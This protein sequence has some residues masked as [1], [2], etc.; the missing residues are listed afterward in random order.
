MEL[1]Q[2]S[3]VPPPSDGKTSLLWR[4]ISLDYDTRDNEKYNRPCIS[5]ITPSYNQGQFIEETIRSVLS[6][7]Y[8]NLEYV[9]IDGASTDNTVSI[10]QKYSG[11]LIWISEPDNGQT[12]AINKGLRMSTGEIVAY[13]N[14]DDVYNEGTFK[15]IVDVFESNP[16]IDMVYGDIIH[17]DQDSSFIETC[18]AD[19]FNLQKYLMGMF[20][21]P[22]PTVFFRKKVIDNIGYFDDSLHLAM[23]YDYWLRIIMYFKTMYIPDTLAMARI[24]KDA[25]S[26]RLDYRYLDERIYILKKMFRDHPDL[27]YDKQKLF[28]YT[29]FMGA[30]TSLRKF[31]FIEAFKYVLLAGKYDL[32]YL[33]NPH[34][35]FACVELFLGEKISNS[36]KPFFKSIYTKNID[37]IY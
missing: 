25:K 14:S 15:K 6:Q 16:D 9:V 27:D 12:D 23:D 8:P 2:Y 33:Y 4:E 36:V 5:I 18:R 29:F 17:I 24:Y 1:L 28:A 7:N 32:H 20:Y 26:S 34:M 10:L 22:Q 13:L 35:F 3:N 11:S 31:K 19:N 30:L 37:E 21:I